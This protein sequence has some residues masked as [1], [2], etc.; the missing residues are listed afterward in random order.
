MSKFSNAAA[1]SSSDYFGDGSG[2]ERTSGD[3][4]LGARSSAELTAS[5]MNQLGGSAVK[6]GGDLWQAAAAVG[7]LTSK[8]SGDVA[9]KLRRGY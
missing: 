2:G 7:S 9:A 6:A 1:I 8:L 3:D 5:L 4:R